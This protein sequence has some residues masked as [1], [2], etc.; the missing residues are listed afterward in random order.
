MAMKK[1]VLSSAP[2]MGGDMIRCCLYPLLVPGNWEFKRNIDGFLNMGLYWNNNLISFIDWRG[3][4]HI[5]EM[6]NKQRWDISENTEVQE[7]LFTIHK[8]HH[9]ESNQDIIDEIMEEAERQE[10]LNPVV[11]FVTVHDIKYQKLAQKNW[12]IKTSVTDDDIA[13]W[14]TEHDKTIAQRLE[15]PEEANEIFFKMG[16]RKHCFFMDTIYEWESFKQEL[17]N[18]MGF[19]R[20]HY[21]DDNFPVIKQFWQKWIDEQRIKVE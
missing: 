1:L 8:R 20:I 7:V 16:D 10:V 13:W 2:G 14:D 4:T 6:Y 15:K 12:L 11:T 9:I 17:K 18:Y 19:Y 3:Q 5:P 21:S